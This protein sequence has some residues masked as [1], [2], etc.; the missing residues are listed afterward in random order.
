[1]K[2]WRYFLRRILLLIPVL[3][4]ILIFAFTLSRIIPADPVKFAAGPNATAEMVEQMRH[5][6]G[7]D[8]PLYEQFILYLRSII[9]GDFGRSLTTRRPVAEDLKRFFPATFELV[10]AAVILGQVIGVPVGVISA[11][12]ENK[13]PDHISRLFALASVSLPSFW[14]ALMLQL[15]IA[16]VLKGILPITGRFDLNQT[17]P[18]TITGLLTIDSLI[19]KDWQ[20]LSISLEHLMLPAM[21]LSSS[22]VATSARMTRSALVA[23]LRKD[24]IMTA[25]ATGLSEIIILFRYALRHALVPIITMMGLEFIWL[26]AGS[27]L[28]ETIFNWPGLGRYIVEASLLLDYNPIMG[29]MIVFGFTAGIT[30]ILVDVAYAIVDPRIRQTYSR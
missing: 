9:T 3:L 20:A 21:A 22:A 26:M 19:H 23:T 12:F 28:V 14:L 4:G 16:W 11:Q 5:E 7:F 27:V 18:S 1:M 10:L 30:N 15:L 25:R 24:F 8:R 6:Y 29:T 2:I 13:W 17:A